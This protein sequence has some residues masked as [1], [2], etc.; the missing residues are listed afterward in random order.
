VDILNRRDPNC[1]LDLLKEFEVIRELVTVESSADHLPEPTL[2]GDRFAIPGTGSN[3]FARWDGNDWRVDAACFGMDTL[4]FFPLGE[5]EASE[6]N[7]ELAKT[8]CSRC[9]VSE[10]CLEFAL[11]TTQNDGIWGGYTEDE[12]RVLKRARRLAARVALKRERNALAKS[13]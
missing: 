2:Y 8:A 11:L 5:G 10:E 1:D 7:A 4:I 3:L 12:R 9:N 13:A 6:R